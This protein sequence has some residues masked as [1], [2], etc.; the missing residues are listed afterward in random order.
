MLY[1]L[2]DGES[3]SST[4]PR[5]PTLLLQEQRSQM[6]LAWKDA[7]C[8]TEASWGAGPG[9]LQAAPAEPD[10]DTQSPPSASESLSAGAS[11]ASL[12][13]AAAGGLA[14]SAA[15]PGGSVD[16]CSWGDLGPSAAGSPARSSVSSLNLSFSLTRASPGVTCVPMLDLT[17]P[18]LI[19]ATGAADVGS[20]NGGSVV[21]DLA[22]S[23]SACARSMDLHPQ[24]LFQIKALRPEAN[25]PRRGY[26]PSAH[27]TYCQPTCRQAPCCSRPT[28]C[29]GALHW[30]HL[31]R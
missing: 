1:C 2:A 30:G 31:E 7:C 10:G 20:S 24:A 25:P 22:S 18:R 8:Q 12:R 11:S 27:S 28:F 15:S 3:Q 4:L 14:P 16:G 13:E 26:Q 29:R 21:Q 19:T 6:R 17:T 23:Q 9:Q 5:R